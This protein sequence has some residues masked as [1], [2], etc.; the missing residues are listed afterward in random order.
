MKFS[1]SILVCLFSYFG[2]HCGEI[3]G[4][5]W[6]GENLLLWEGD[7]K[8]DRVIVYCNVKTFGRCDG[9]IF[10]IPTYE[11]HMVNGVYNEYVI[12]ARSNAKWII[13]TSLLIK[14]HQLNYWIIN[15]DFNINKVDCIRINCD[16][17]IQS[18]I[19]GP[20]TRNDFDALRKDLKIDLNF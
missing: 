20:L 16:S 11:R 19:K 4:S 6:L 2:I 13:A 14:N 1:I 9:G 10:V 3:T 5:N 15:K 17:V 8:E 7:K 18:H 12:G